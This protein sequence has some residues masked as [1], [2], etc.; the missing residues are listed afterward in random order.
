MSKNLVIIPYSAEKLDLDKLTDK[1]ID[2][3][4]LQ[5]NTISKQYAQAMKTV[6]A[7]LFE[8]GRTELPS[9]Q[10]QEYY[11]G[12]IVPDRLPDNIAQEVKK[13]QA[14]LK[15]IKDQY[16]VQQRVIKL[17]PRRFRK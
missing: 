17:A 4:L 6:R 9:F 14:R 10:V 8:T 7:F 3:R 15:E 12:K 5:F 13:L 2:D 11:Q 1:Q 16:G